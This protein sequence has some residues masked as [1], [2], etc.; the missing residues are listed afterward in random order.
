MASNWIKEAKESHEA[1]NTYADALERR[2]FELLE[3]L[4]DAVIGYVPSDWEG[5]PL[6]GMKELAGRRLRDFAKQSLP[7]RPYRALW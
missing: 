6:D 4:K 2:N 5:A 7:K 1:L 3:A